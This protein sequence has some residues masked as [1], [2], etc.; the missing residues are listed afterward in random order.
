MTPTSEESNRLAHLLRRAGFGARPAE[1]TKYS[2]LGLAGTT[3]RLLHPAAAPNPADTVMQEIGEDFFKLDDRSGIQYA[4]LYRMAHSEHPLEEKMTLFWH[5]HFATADYKVDNPRLMWGQNQTLRRHALGSFRTV[6]QA[7]SRDPAMLIWLDGGQNKKEQPNENFGRE[8]LE[9]FT[10]GV[11]SGYTE[12]D[13]KEAARAFTGWQV[14]DG[15]AVFHADEHD[16]GVKTFLGHTGSFS[17]DDIVDILVKHPATAHFLSVKLFR[18]FVHD[19]PT[20]DDIAPLARA[21]LVSGYSILAVVAQILRS[22][23]FYSSEARYAKWKS[24]TE[25]LLILLRTLDAPL[26][27]YDDLPGALASMGQ[28][29]FNP[30]NVK[31]WR[32]GRHWINTQSVLVRL[33]QATQMQDRMGDRLGGSLSRALQAAGTDPSTLDTSE[34][35]VTALWS[36]LLPGR[37]LQPHTREALLKY[38]QDPPGDDGKVPAFD[39]SAKSPG[40]LSLILV[41]PEYQLV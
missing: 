27:A 19:H 17:G 29:L 10:M 24:P 11:G 31:G 26:T 7:V 41:A 40:L 14:E 36:L 39:F 1:W 25:H 8:L 16:D 5:N 23:V 30:P 3:E 15:K 33:N 35:A 37:A 18:F 13:V 6:L 38:L 4:W 32:E 12:T 20:P 21:F 28:D 9:L 34:K 2:A 22:S